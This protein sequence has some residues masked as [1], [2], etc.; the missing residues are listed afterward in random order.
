MR[1]APAALALVACG[2]AAGL[3]GAQAPDPQSGQ[4]LFV[5]HC[6]QCHGADARGTGPM[7]E[8]IAI[9]TPDLT[10]LSAR[11]GGAFPLEAVARQ[12]DGRAPLLAHGGDMPVFGPFLDS[13]GRAV[14]ELPSG[15]P[16]MT[17]VP[18]A[19]LLVFLQTVQA[20]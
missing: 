16:M 17:S 4:A 3:A 18:V 13:D 5:T 1:V 15:Q 8:I 10:G 6:A 2:M 12:I 7:A 20:P 9:D 11:N 14:F 19:D